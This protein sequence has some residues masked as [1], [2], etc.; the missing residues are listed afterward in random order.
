[1]ETLTIDERQV[2]INAIRASEAAYGH[3]IEH[4]L[5]F[6]NSQ[7]LTLANRLSSFCI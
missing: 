5:C 3:R 2:V 6:R 7:I 4:H 1:M